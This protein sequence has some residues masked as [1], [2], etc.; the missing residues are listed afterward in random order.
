MNGMILAE[1][2]GPED[3]LK[4]AAMVRD[5]GYRGFDCH[6]PFPIHGMDEAMGL[7]RS[8]LGWIVGAMAFI[9]GLGAL[10]LQWWTSAVDYPII[11]AG[12][13]FFSFQAF[14]PVTFGLAVLFGAF[15]T[16]IGLVA[17]SKLPRYVHPVFDIDEFDKFSND[18][19]FISIPFHEPSFDTEKAKNYLESIGGRNVIINRNVQSKN[20]DS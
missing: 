19:F 5:D 10:I 4:A 1:F 3:L 6:S 18:G 17:L 20:E 12:K 11:I 14:V 7:K 13:P 15:A 8:P 16:F 9:G 2:D